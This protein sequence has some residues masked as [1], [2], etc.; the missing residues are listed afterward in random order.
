MI[1]LRQEDAELESRLRRYARKECL[2]WR[3]RRTLSLATLRKR[4]I[5]FCAIA[6]PAEFFAALAAAGVEMVER[7]SFRDHHRYTAADMESWRSLAGVMDARH[8][9]ITGKDEV[10]LDAAMR[11]RLNAVA[12]LRTAGLAG[13]DGG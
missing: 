3:V 5:A 7:M 13:R 6:R 2:F 10:K 4:A 8:L 12:P 9:S 1:V 11:L